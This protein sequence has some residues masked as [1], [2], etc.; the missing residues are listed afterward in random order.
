LSPESHALA[1]FRRVNGLLFAC[2]DELAENCGL[3]API[4]APARDLTSVSNRIF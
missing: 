1:M 2:L 4:L 3:S